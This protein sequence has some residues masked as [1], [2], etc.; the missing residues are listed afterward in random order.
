[1]QNIGVQGKVIA[2]DAN[3]QCI[4]RYFADEFWQMPVQE[5]LTIE[6]LLAICSD[7]AIKAI[8]PTRD[9]ELP[10]FARHRETLESRGIACLVSQ[11]DAVEKCRNKILFYKTLLEN[12]FPVIPAYKHP[13]GGHCLSYVVK[14]CF[15]S[16][17]RAIG[18]DLSLSRAKEWA[19]RMNTPIFQPFVRGVEYSVDLY[20]DKSGGQKGAVARRRDL[21]IDGESQITTSERLPAAEETCLKAASLLGIYGHAVFQLIIDLSGHLHIIE[22]NPRFGGASTLSV[23]MGLKTFEWFLQEALGLP[24]SPFARMKQEMRQVRFAEDKLI[25]LS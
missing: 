5:L 16:G 7:L 23:A 15:G 9:G 10:F 25:G 4:A 1:M 21:V 11:E 12:N 18:L 20:I 24:V 22:C 3:K 2:G 13:E 19:K 17:S 14:E 6:E 8:I